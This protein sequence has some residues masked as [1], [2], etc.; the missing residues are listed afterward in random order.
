MSYKQWLG[1]KEH[2]G[3]VRRYT[4]AEKVDKEV[5]VMGHGTQ[6]SREVVFVPDPSPPLCL[7]PTHSL[8]GTRELSS[9]PLLLSFSTRC[10]ASPLGP[11]F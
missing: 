4:I 3:Q 11:V 2:V 8:S 5:C 7:A 1:M 9:D 6:R 10:T